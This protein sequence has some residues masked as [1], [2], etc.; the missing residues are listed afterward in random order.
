MLNQPG[1]LSRYNNELYWT[2]GIRFQ[3]G[4]RDFSLLHS[5]QNGSDSNTASYP[6]GTSD[7]F[8]RG[9]KAGA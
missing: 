3:V 2:A 8:S 9:K 1:E 4:A 7:S 6:M 5:I